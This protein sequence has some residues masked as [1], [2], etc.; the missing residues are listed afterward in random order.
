MLKINDVV[1]VGTKGVCLVE[2]IKKNAFVGCEKNKE[3]YVL[4]PINSTT[5][6]VVFLPTDTSLKIRPLVTKKEIENILSSLE[7]TN[8][9]DSIKEENRF[10]VYNDVMKSG[11]FADRVGLLKVLFERKKTIPKKQF[12]SQEQKILDSVLNALLEEMSIVLNSDKEN[13]RDV[14]FEKLE[15]LNME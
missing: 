3:Y 15:V 7:K 12:S 9:K 4:K 5:N 13:V 11:D 10:N 6:M 2:D 8:I 1:F 14:L